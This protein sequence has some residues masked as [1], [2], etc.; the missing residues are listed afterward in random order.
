M[1][2]CVVTSQGRKGSRSTFGTPTSGVVRAVDGTN[3]A[4]HTNPTCVQHGEQIRSG[5]RVRLYVG[6]AGVTEAQFGSFL[7]L[8]VI[9]RLQP[10]PGVYEIVAQDA[11][12][13]LQ[14]TTFLRAAPDTASFTNTV[15]R[16][17]HPLEILLNVW[18]TTSYA[19]ASG[20]APGVAQNGIYDLG[21]GNGLGIPTALV[22]VTSIQNL[23]TTQFP[24]EIY[25]Y[26]FREPVE[27]K[28]WT[29]QLLKSLNCYPVVTGSGTLSVKRIASSGTAVASLTHDTIIGVPRWQGGD[30]LVANHLSVLY[31]WGVSSRVGEYTTRDTFVANESAA[32]Y[33]LKSPFVIEALGIRTDLGGADVALSRAQ[34][35]FERYADPPPVL[36]TDVLFSQLRL[37]PGDTVTVTH[38]HVP[39]LA[40]GQIGIV[41]EQFEVTDVRP[42]FNPA[43]G[44]PR[45]TLTLLHTG[46]PRVA[47]TVSVTTATAP[48]ITYKSG[49]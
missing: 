35:F 15:T 37:E 48:T 47:Q 49:R 41:A 42:V 17:G 23:M 33:G 24:G 30:T 8:D 14:R 7:K 28:A 16:Q 5:E 29:E 22:E 4:V 26:L 9:Q 31:D 27:G 38:S 32:K 39:N 11:Q 46:F 20:Q 2:A 21:D 10:Q 1:T 13:M 19:G 12:R 18:T 34:R 44:S 45:V 36:Q 25:C 40:T 43:E 6:N 3:A